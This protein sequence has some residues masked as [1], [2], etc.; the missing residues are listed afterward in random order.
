M[1]VI[2][3][4]VLF[5]LCT[6]FLPSLGFYSANPD[7][8]SIDPTRLSTYLAL[9]S[10]GITVIVILLLLISKLGGTI[11]QG[12]SGLVNGIGAMAL[13]QGNFLLWNFGPLDGRG[14]QWETQAYL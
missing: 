2:R 5:S 1:K 14:M 9:V 7:E 8:F 11:F 4:G 13:I 6:V 12:L 10:L 3:L